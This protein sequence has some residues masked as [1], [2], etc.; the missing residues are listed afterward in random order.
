MSSL[1]TKTISS[2]LSCTKCIGISK[3]NSCFELKELRHGDFQVF[4][5][6]LPQIITKYLCRTRNTYGTLRGRNQVNFQRK[7]KP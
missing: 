6:K 2:N 7:N 1:N 4:W 5:S 3:E